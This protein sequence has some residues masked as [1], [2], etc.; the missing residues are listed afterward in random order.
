MGFDRDSLYSLGVQLSAFLNTVEKYADVLKPVW[1][2]IS[3][4]L[5]GSLA[6]RYLAFF[7]RILTI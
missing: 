2:A 3:E 6:K 7:N 1:W 5:I 4:I